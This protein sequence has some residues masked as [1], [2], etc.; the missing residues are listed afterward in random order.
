[1]HGQRSKTLSNRWRSCFHSS[2]DYGGRSSTR[3]LREPLFHFIAIGG[4]IF[5]LYTAVDDTGE[6]PADVIVIT[7]ERIEQLAAGFNSVWKRMTR[8]A[9]STL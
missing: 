4:L 1:M 2:S 3:L 7:P 5:A 6:A 9:R 8:M